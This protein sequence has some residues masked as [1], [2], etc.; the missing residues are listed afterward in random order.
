MTPARTTRPSAGWRILGGAI[1]LIVAG[2]YNQGAVLRDWE[3]V[4][5]PWGQDA[6]HELEV[7]VEGESGMAEHAYRKAFLA[8]AKGSS[9]DAIRLLEIGLRVV[10]R[11]SPDMITL[12]R[13]MAVVS[14]MAAAITVVEP[15]RP[16]DF[17]LPSLSRLV[18]VAGFVHRLLV[19]RIRCRDAFPLPEHEADRRAPGCGAE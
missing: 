3:M 14:R 5:E 19:A 8:H 17:R 18:A 7:R 6:Y 16:R 15:L 4:L 1:A 10:E 13:G 2:L 9:E 11:T 12:L